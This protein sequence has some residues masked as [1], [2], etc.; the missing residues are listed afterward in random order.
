MSILLLLQSTA[1]PP[2]VGQTAVT[3]Y[4]GPNTKAVLRDYFTNVTVPT[5][6][7][8]SRSEIRDSFGIT[9][10][11]ASYRGYPKLSNAIFTQTG[12]IVNLDAN[13]A[14]S[15][16]G[17]GTTW[18]SIA[19]A[20]NYTLVNGPTYTSGI[21]A[22]FTADGTNDYI[23]STNLKASFTTN[24][25]SIFMW[26]YPI[27][28][29][30]LYVELG[31]NTVNTG[32]HASNIEINTS[33][34]FSFSLWH[35]SLTSKVVSS[36]QSFNQWYYVGLT[37]SGTSLNAYINGVNIGSTTFTRSVNSTFYTALFPIDTTNMGTGSY[38][39]SRVNSLHMYNTAITAA[40]VLQNYNYL[41][42]RFGLP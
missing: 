9:I 4:Y 41:K 40:D 37:Y 29:G 11:Q 38:S 28:A 20:F 32:W 33:G 19:S 8:P 13:N 39:N 27:T 23:I 7:I 31:Q 21:P 5:A 36:N 25:I 10:A 26:V 18:T 35:N 1:A 12:L 24:D 14:S 15:Y 34:A 16:T 3:S 2:V 30:Q 42:S 17:T 6:V 22:Y